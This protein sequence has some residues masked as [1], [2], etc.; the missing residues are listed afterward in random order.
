MAVLLLDIGNSRCKA[1]LYQQ[2]AF[3]LLASHQAA[4]LADFAIEA[5]FCSSVANTERYQEIQQ[6]TGLA[7]LNWTEIRSEASRHGLTSCY[8]QPHLL[9]VDRWL[10]ML[11]ARTLWPGQDLLVIDAG[12]AI[13]VDWVDATGQHLGGWIL[14]GLR[15]LEKS[16]TTNTARVFSQDGLLSGLQPGTSTG[17]CLQ[18]GC[19]AAAAG[20]LQ[21][22]LQLRAVSTVI[23]TGGD[24]ATLLPYLQ[25]DFA[26]Q[27]DPLLIFRGLALYLPKT[28][29]LAKE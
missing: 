29:K 1:V 6:Q 2:G 12:T 23:C 24:A 3:S 7:Q 9:G 27:L 4:D 22:A 28:A 10:A 8:Q 21:A 15:L 25:S 17:A 5:V 26:I 20:A 11:G 19:L 16:V 14:P 18:N 13:T